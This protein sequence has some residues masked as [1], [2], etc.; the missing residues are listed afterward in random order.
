MAGKEWIGQIWRSSDPSGSLKFH[1]QI[2][3]TTAQ[4]AAISRFM[5]QHDGP[6]PLRIP[7]KELTLI[8][9]MADEMANCT[10]YMVRDEDGEVAGRDPKIDKAIAKVRAVFNL[11]KK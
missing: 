2:C 3:P 11:E 6:K 9:A 4:L 1:G 5:Q 10:D 7:R 8:A